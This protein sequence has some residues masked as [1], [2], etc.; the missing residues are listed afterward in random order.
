MSYFT[1]ALWAAIV[2]S[3]SYLP[4]VAFPLNVEVM[5]RARSSMDSGWSNPAHTNGVI[6]IL[7][8]RAYPLQKAHTCSL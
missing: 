5:A 1:Q 8:K 6:A 7:L 3:R 4:I 2:E